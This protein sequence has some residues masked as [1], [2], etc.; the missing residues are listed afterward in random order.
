MFNEFLVRMGSFF[1]VIGLGLI[2]LFALTYMANAPDFNFFFLGLVSIYV[3]WRLSRR[4]A[5]PPPS[6]R[7]ATIR[8]WRENATKKPGEKKE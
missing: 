4:K 7:F 8:K 6:G 5:P 3:G 1:T 2:I